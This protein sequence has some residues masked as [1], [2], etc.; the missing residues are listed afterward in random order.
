[1]V[2]TSPGGPFSP[3]FPLNSFESSPAMPQYD[4]FIMLKFKIL[5]METMNILIDVPI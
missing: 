3:G 1:M 4:S 5:K 2:S